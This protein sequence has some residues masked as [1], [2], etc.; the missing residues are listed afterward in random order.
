MNSY[1]GQ[2]VINGVMIMG[3][4][5]S[6]IAVRSP[7]EEIIKREISIKK[8]YSSKFNKIP[9]LRGILSLLDQLRTGVKAINLSE[10]IS[11]GRNSP[12]GRPSQH[13]RLARNPCASTKFVNNEFPG[14]YSD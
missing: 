7:A 6:V 8:L 14:R 5:T 12:K 2:A 11:R 1:G 10:A 9:I 3:R 13:G 4:N